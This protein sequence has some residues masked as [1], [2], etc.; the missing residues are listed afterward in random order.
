MI[1]RRFIL[2]ATLA[3]MATPLVHACAKKGGHSSIKGYAH[4]IGFLG[5]R[6]AEGLKL[7]QN[8]T[9]NNPSLL[10][11]L[12]LA[13]GE[14]LQTALPLERGHSVVPLADGRLVCI[15]QNGDKAIVVNANHTNPTTLK[16]GD[17]LAFGGHGWEDTQNGTL[18]LPLMVSPARSVKDSGTLRLYDTKTLDIIHER[19]SGGIHPHE[20][21]TLK[22]GE[23]LAITHYGDVRQIGREGPFHFSPASP[24]LS[25]YKRQTLKN[26]AH[27]NQDDLNGVLTHLCLAPDGD[28]ITVSNQYL[29]FNSGDEA[30]VLG[31]VEK[32][33]TLH[34]RAPSALTQPLVEENRLALIQPVR[35]TNP[36]TGKTILLA[37]GDHGFSRSQSVCTHIGSGRVFATFS[38]SNSLFI[39]NKDG[40]YSRQSAQ[41]YGIHNLR[42]V[43]ALEETPYLLLTDR[44]KGIAVINATTLELH[45]TFDV[46]LYGSAHI[47]IS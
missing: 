4:T 47:T 43:A 40:S 18:L 27:Y 16:A 2:G 29:P 12:N 22:S 21:T 10:S 25:I 30:S 34:G 11:S 26:I 5:Q 37:D 41:P 44:H 33:T 38:F 6:H 19:T 32:F 20:I 13:T 36:Q 14:I 28:I 46:A 7:W 3:S 42:G 39:L 23:R 9:F 15:P 24:C 8:G 31:A 45:S 35:K 17:G 1:S